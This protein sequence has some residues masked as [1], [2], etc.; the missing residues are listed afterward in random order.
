MICFTATREIPQPPKSS[1]GAGR[2]E[3]APQR[4]EKIESGPGNGM[5]SEAS[6]PQHL[7]RGRA[8][9]RAPL[10][11]T[12]RNVGAQPRRPT[13]IRRSPEIRKS[14]R[15]TRIPTLTVIARSPCDEA[16]QGPRAVAPGLLRCARNDGGV[17]ATIIGHRLS[18]APLEKRSNESLLVCGE[19]PACAEKWKA[20]FI[21]R[22]RPEAGV[23]PARK[24]LWIF[25]PRNRIVCQVE[26]PLY[27]DRGS[28]M[29]ASSTELHRKIRR[30]A[31]RARSEAAE[32][33]PAASKN[34]AEKGR[35]EKKNL[36]NIKGR[37]EAL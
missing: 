37:L 6:N 28:A 23:E 16:I 11:L 5:V 22:D 33:G 24:N 30:A 9:D 29:N 36:K 35:S 20:R 10:R 14:T 27:L 18:R 3:M 34:A 19:R 15:G 25:L 21:L 7:V 2:S 26:N 12:S 1:L 31:G 17:D 13:A 8:A 4:L 32:C